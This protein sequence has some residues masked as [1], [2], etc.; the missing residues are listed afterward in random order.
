M[1][2]KKIEKDIKIEGMHCNH[3]A[4]KVEKALLSI[5]GVKAVSVDVASG[6]VKIK[7]KCEIDNNVLLKTIED[8][9]Y[10]LVD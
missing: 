8:L 7:S 4:Q 10:K 6:N 3:C 9:G 1:F 2:G 5:K